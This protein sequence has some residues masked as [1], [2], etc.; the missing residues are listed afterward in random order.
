MRSAGL[1]ENITPVARWRDLVDSVLNP[2]CNVSLEPPCKYLSAT[3]ESDQASNPGRH[4]NP[5]LMREQFREVVQSRY[6]GL[7]S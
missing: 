2:M 4:P 7:Y 1:Q 5:Q 6:S 3:A